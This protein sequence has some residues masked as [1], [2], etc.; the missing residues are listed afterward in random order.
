[1]SYVGFDL[2]KIKISIM[3]LINKLLGSQNVFQ[4]GTQN[5]ILNISDS[6]FY[7]K[8]EKKKSYPY[9]NSIQIWRILQNIKV[10]IKMHLHF[11][12]YII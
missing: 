9:N 1:M 11:L 10:F 4:R 7:E 8:K 6:F 5:K 2:S 12:I 3:A